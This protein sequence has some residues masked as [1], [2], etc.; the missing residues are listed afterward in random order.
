MTSNLANFLTHFPD[1]KRCGKEWKAHCPAHDD[2]NPSLSIDEKVEKGE[3]RVLF[4]C[5]SGCSQEAVIQ[6]IR[7]RARETGKQLALSAPLSALATAQQPESKQPIP[8]NIP[9][10]SIITVYEY[11]SA[12]GEVL[13]QNVRLIPPPDKDKDFKLRHPDGNGGWLF[14]RGEI[15]AT[16]YNLPEVLRSDRILLCEGEKD[17]NTAKGLGFVATT[18]GAANSWKAE[19]ANHFAGKHV[20]FIPDSDRAGRIYASAVT[21]DVPDK[22]ASFKVLELPNSKDLSEWTEKGGTKE[23]LQAL[24]DSSPEWHPPVEIKERSIILPV[25]KANYR[26]DRKPIPFPRRAIRGLFDEYIA[27]MQTAT[28]A[29]DAFHF[30][31]LWA[32]IA[33]ALGRRMNFYLGLDLYPNVYLACF[34]PTGDRKTSATRNVLHLG[35]EFNHISGGGSAEGISDK[36]STQ[37]AGE[38][39]LI[40]GEELSSILRPGKWDGATLLPFLTHCFDCPPKYEMAFRKQKIALLEPTPSLL[41][42]TTPTWFWDD[43]NPKDIA[44][45]FGNRIFYFAGMPKDLIALP[46]KPQLESVSHKIGMLSNLKPMA[47]TLDAD[48]QTLWE[49]YYRHE[50]HKKGQDPYSLQG[51][52]TRRITL[53]VMKLAMAFSASESSSGEITR[54][55]LEAAIAVGRYG[56]ECVGELLSLRELTPSPRKELEKRII[57]FVRSEPEGRASKRTICQRLHCDAETFN[58]TLDALV[59][60]GQLYAQT[61]DRRDSVWVSVE[62]S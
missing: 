27:A 10:K 60:A 33:T 15:P 36:L 40:Y 17:C 23:A 20:V 56:E 21:A 30:A 46:K 22:T 32:R 19:F 37:T 62:P 12:T 13:Y 5:R 54:D 34:G 38:G 52:A 7:G 47:A 25:D 3:S 31:T 55:H 14:G 59:R 35:N 57:D 4:I 6:A 29:S 53:Y 9:D 49:E 8:W 39:V 61:G 41:A 44:G 45:G 2:R 58:R 11:T 16:L 26:P 24:I 28:E 48:A 42:G 43:M 1:A 51:M 50:H 18:S